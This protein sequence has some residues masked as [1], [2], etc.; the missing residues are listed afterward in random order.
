MLRGH[1][2]ALDQQKA[3]EAAA[4]VLKRQQMKAPLT[5]S[6]STASPRGAA[7]GAVLRTSSNAPQGRTARSSSTASYRGRVAS[8]AAK[9]L[10]VYQARSAFAGN[11][12]YEDV[13]VPAPLVV[14]VA[15]TLNI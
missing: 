3:A 12:D 1:I 7:P 10:P 14:D 8:H 6:G 4:A 2:D 5:T 9:V 11:S 15:R 13:D